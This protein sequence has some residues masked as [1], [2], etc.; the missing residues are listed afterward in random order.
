[1]RE[2]GKWW[3]WVVVEWRKGV[4]CKDSS[5]LLRKILKKIGVI[6]EEKQD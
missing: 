2:R 5:T 4:D 3:T 6:G 1:M